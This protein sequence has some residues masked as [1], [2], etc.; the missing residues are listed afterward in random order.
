MGC[1]SARSCRNDSRSTDWRST[2]RRR[3]RSPF[4]RPDCTS[5]DDGPGSFDLLGFT[6]HWA[7]SRRGKW[8]VKRRTANDRFARALGRV[9]QWCKQNRHLPLKVQWR[10]LVQKLR[11]H[12]A[13][14]GIAGNADAIARFLH[15]VTRVWRTWLSRRSQVGW[16]TWERMGQILARYPLPP[17]RVRATTWSK[18]TT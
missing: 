2:Q 5:K 18:P 1:A 17:P 4:R 11:G 7:L 12:Y 9:T 15:E 3:G 16:V 14:Y 13:F 6:H 8:V 10:T